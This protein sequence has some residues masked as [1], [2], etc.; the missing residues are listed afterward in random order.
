MRP[1]PG[2]R[3]RR[4][5]VGLR[6]PEVDL[7]LPAVAGRAPAVVGPHGE[8]A[9][10]GVDERV[11]DRRGTRAA[12]VEQLDDDVVVA[13]AEGGGQ[14]VRLEPVEVALLVGV[15]PALPAG[16]DAVHDESTGAVG[17]EQDGRR[18][19]V[20][21]Q[22]HDGREGDDRALRRR[23]GGAQ[24]LRPPVP[25][26]SG[27]EGE[28]ARSGSTARRRSGAG[29]ARCRRRAAGPGR[30]RGGPPPRGPPPR[31]SATPPSRRRRPPRDACRAHRRRH[32]ARTWTACPA[33]TAPTSMNSS[34]TRPDGPS[35]CQWTG[36]LWMPRT[37]TTRPRA[38]RRA[39]ASAAAPARRRV[40]AARGE[41]PAG[42]ERN[43]GRGG[44]TRANPLPIHPAARAPT[45]PSRVGP[46]LGASRSPQSSSSVAL[47]LDLPRAV[48]HR[49][50]RRRPCRPRRW[51]GRP[52]SRP[53]RAAHTT[54]RE[55]HAGRARRRR[56]PPRRPRAGRRR[57]AP[58]LRRALDARTRHVEG[59]GSAPRRTGTRARAPRTASRPDRRRP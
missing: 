26:A 18:L 6:E 14:V 19:G 10:R 11:E 22:R 21:G 53:T 59:R 15:E 32:T 2:V 23:P 31:R 54:V 48:E 28:C 3:V 49:R 20:G 37:V 41:R 50:P 36:S 39:E 55:R 7:D 47:D 52:R 33:S 58:K 16:L 25:S 8:R 34:G 4:I 56:Q 45:S 24:P 40:T 35:A 12:H 57:T 29:R 13:R 44:G 46:A 51:R 43:A 30:S 17:A 27:D 5:A 42:D 1:A 38:S 9:V